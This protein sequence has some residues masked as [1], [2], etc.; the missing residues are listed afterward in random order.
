MARIRGLAQ[1]Q[2]T[3]R[4]LPKKLEAEGMAAINYAVDNMI[5]DAKARAP[6]DLFKLINSIDKEDKDNGWTVV[7]FVGEVHGAFQEFG[8]GKQ[9][10]VPAELSGIASEFR[11]YK[12]GSF[13]QFVEDIE[14][15]C[16]RKGID[17][18]AAYPIALSILNRGLAPQPYFWPAYLKHRDTIIP[19]IKERIKRLWS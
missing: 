18:Q 15:W 19:D 14:A 11:G 9:V 8:T 4:D 2:K 10:S 16:V 3:L 17:P 13:E 12:S 5:R 6:Q 1:L 7:F